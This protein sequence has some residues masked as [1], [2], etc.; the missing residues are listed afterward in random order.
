MA[1][2][3]NIYGIYNQF[4]GYFPSSL[5]GLISFALGILLVVGIY[6]VLKRQLIYLVLLVILLPAAGPIMKNIWE[7]LLEVLK[8]LFTKK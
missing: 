4:L 5:H 7:Q 8:F 3:Q 2:F 6:K 1:A